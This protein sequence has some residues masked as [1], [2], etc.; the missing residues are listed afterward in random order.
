[1]RLEFSCLFLADQLMRV[2]TQMAACL[3]IHLSACLPAYLFTCFNWP[4]A[5]HRRLS[6]SQ[7][8]AHFKAE[9]EEDEEELAASN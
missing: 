4:I 6:A 1:M 3:L 7:N 9:E 8:R 2:M 5:I